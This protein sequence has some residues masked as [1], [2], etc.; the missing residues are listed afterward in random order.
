MYA[1]AEYRL[2]V[3]VSVGHLQDTLGCVGYDLLDHIESNEFWTFWE[4]I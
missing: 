2:V 1:D 3:W 4:E